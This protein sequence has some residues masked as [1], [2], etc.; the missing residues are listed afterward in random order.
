MRDSNHQFGPCFK[1]FV[2]QNGGMAF[3]FDE[4]KLQRRVIEIDHSAITCDSPDVKKRMDRI[5][6]NFVEL[7]E[8]LERMESKIATNSTLL[9][10]DEEVRLQKEA[11]LAAAAEKAAIAEAT[12]DE[13]G[14]P[15]TKK[16]RKKRSPNKPR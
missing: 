8:V 14:L 3:Y 13:V 2:T 10:R 16:S 11:A 1:D 4:S 5:E 6:S 15:Q 9:R 7:D 12:A